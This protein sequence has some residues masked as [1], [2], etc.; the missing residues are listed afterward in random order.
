MLMR[1]KDWML[2]RSRRLEVRSEEADAR[3]FVDV[4]ITASL[5]SIIITPRLLI[6]TGM[7]GSVANLALIC[8]GASGM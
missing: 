4:Y 8:T 5:D 2:V 6:S 1:W 3:A 7:K